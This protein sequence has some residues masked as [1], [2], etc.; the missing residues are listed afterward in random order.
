MKVEKT[1]L[2]DVLVVTP[3][4]F[5]DERG[6]FSEAFNLDRFTKATGL[7]RTWVQDNES[8]SQRGVLRGLHFQNPRPQGK[9]VRCVNGAVFDVAVDIRRSSPHFLQWVGY[10]LSVENH[11]QLWIPEGFAHGFY[12]LTESA[13]L[14]YKTTDYYVADADRT[15]RWDDPD[16]GIVWP[17]DG[18]PTLS[19]KDRAAPLLAEAQ[20]FD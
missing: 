10:E 15:I 2:E 5:G 14:Q 7:S 16:I 3:M 9:L 20:V 12:A 13:T 18:E 4:V 6:S 8:V 17:L 1:S 11:A 19:D